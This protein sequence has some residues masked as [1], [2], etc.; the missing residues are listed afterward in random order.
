[1]SPWPSSCSAPCSLRMVRLSILEATLKLMR[2][3]KFALMVPVTMSTDGRC[4]AMM[5][6]M[7]AARAICARRCTAALDLL[8]GDDH[9]IGELVD[10]DDDVRHR[11][12]RH[13]LLL[14]DGF[15]G[16]VVEAGLH[17]ARKMLAAALRLAHARVEGFDVAHRQRRHALVALL[18]LADGPVERG[19]GLVRV[20]DDGRQQMRNAVV[21]R[22]LE[23]LRVDHQEAAVFRRAP[24]QQRQDHGVD[25]DRLAR[26]GGAGDEQ[27]RHACEVGDDGL[28]ADRLAECH[29][30]R[31]VGRAEGIA[32]RRSRAGR[33]SRAARSAARCR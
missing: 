15:A 30:Q 14:V 8:A 10:D 6:W 23:H 24:I 20:G 11:L 33:P 4:V 21:D 27:M 31:G 16:A 2:A 25:A 18:H 12:G 26:A 13:L 3:G 19:D 5:R 28:A 22:Q 32:L 29:G 7:P 9:Q 1:M 17:G